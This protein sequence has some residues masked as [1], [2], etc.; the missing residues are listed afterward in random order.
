MP[1]DLTPKSFKEISAKDK[2]TIPDVEYA[3]GGSGGMKI[4]SDS[5]TIGEGDTTFKITGEGIHLGAA[6]FNDAPFSVNLDGEVVADSLTVTGGIIKYGK[7]SFTDDTNSGYYVSSDG[8]YFG[9][10]SD[11][12]VLKFDIG[13]GLMSY[14]GNLNDSLGNIVL[15]S[16]ART[17]LKDFDFGTTDYAG[18]VKAGDITWNTTTG[19][20]TGGS[21]VAV[22]RGGIVGASGG[23]PTFTLD[24]T[25]GN[26]TFSGTITGSTVTGGTI[27]TSAT[28]ERVVMTSN[29]LSAYDAA[30]NATFELDAESNSQIVSINTPAADSRLGLLLN[31]DGTGKPLQI[32]V[33]NASNT[34]DAFTIIS[35]GTGSGLV[36]DMNSTTSTNS[37]LEIANAGLGPDVS[38][39]GSRSITMPS[40][41]SNMGINDIANIYN[42]LWTCEDS[43][44][45]KWVPLE[46][47]NIVYRT[48]FDSLDGFYIYDTAFGGPTIT[49]QTSDAARRITLPLRDDSGGGSSEYIIRKTLG[50]K[51]LSWGKPRYCRFDVE[52]GS[53][54]YQQQLVFG[55]GRIL[56]KA[57]D[58]A[59]TI[60]GVGAAF[61]FYKDTVSNNWNT[62]AVSGFDS[63]HP[64]YFY[65][66]EELGQ[67]MFSTGTI[68]RFEI[69]VIPPV[70]AET[71]NG[72]ILF[73]I[74]GELV[75]NANFPYTLSMSSNEKDVM[76][77]TGDRSPSNITGVENYL[78]NWDFWQGI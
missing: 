58:S 36:L 23:T 48:S 37:P 56:P 63:A 43:D 49:P 18:A 8:L 34:S 52:F 74:D 54:Q 64:F 33:D 19:A 30:D 20:I 16:S 50:H 60:T 55:L 66:A 27:Q 4:T 73:Y 45:N 40:E 3:L 28:G 71:K 32:Q 69:L 44:N 11:A 38:F 67:D 6:D 61:V 76:T 14:S 53:V 12:T 51:G 46:M 75:H 47:R 31:I 13:T 29:K 7:T 21:G 57:Y 77:V 65:S 2:I 24:S 15:D 1:E 25:N 41:I 9:S 17:I 42:N 59:Q 22:Y 26:A 78:Y 72:E 5:L 62:Y 68:Y 39:S 70:S 35:S 10:V